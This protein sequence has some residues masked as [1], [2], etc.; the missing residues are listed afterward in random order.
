MKP[1]GAKKKVEGIVKS[2]AMDR[3]ISVSVGRL[4]KEPRYH[5]YI[6]RHSI[7]KAHDENNEAGVGD[8][9]RLIATKPLSKTKHWRLTKI[10]EKA[11][12]K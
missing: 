4:V 1:R 3:T 11:P 8:R 6:R 9:V 12:E 2:A 5:K 10:L 7:F